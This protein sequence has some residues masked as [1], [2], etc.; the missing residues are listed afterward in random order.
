MSNII[1]KTTIDDEDLANFPLTNIL[2]PCQWVLFLYDKSLF[3]KIVTRTNFKAKPHKEMCNIKTVNDI[4]YIL[5]LME[6]KSE[7]KPGP[8]QALEIIDTGKINLDINDYI[9]MRK[10]IEPIWEDPKNTNGGSFTIKIN[11]SKGYDL[12][13]TFVMH[14][15]GETLTYDMK[16]I[17]G[18]SV[19]FIP[20][21]HNN[22][23]DVNSSFTYIK[24]WDGMPNRTLDQFMKILPIDLL[25]KI[26][27]ASVQY[28]AH[29]SK[30]NYGHENI[31]NKIN[32]S[33]RRHR[34]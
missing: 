15:V 16:Y 9:I 14:M 4:V 6:V 18:I 34:K 19:S 5:Q 7:S 24:I 25:N 17:N 11:H 13:S 8:I 32:Y 29:N 22:T 1:E 21:N 27:G 12:W 3:K 28:T 10:D 20:D 30:R 31:I 23:H 2:L 33:G 26:K